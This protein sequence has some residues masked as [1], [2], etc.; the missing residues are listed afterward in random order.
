M[1]RNGIRQGDIEY[2]LFP[3]Y[4]GYTMFL[5]KIALTNFR[6]YADFKHTFK[7]NVL[8]LV[9]PNA[10]GKT[11]FL[12]SISVLS[13]SKSFRT[14][15]DSELIQFD[16][17]FTRL[18]GE[19][20][21]T[22]K[23]TPL[24]ITVDRL[25]ST[26]KKTIK[27]NS[28]P[29]RALDLV[30]KMTTVLFT[31]DDLNLVFASPSLRRRYLDTTICQLDPAYCRDLTEYR[32]VVSNKNQLLWAIKEGRA[33]VAELDFWNDKLAKIG[34]RLMASRRQLIKFYNTYLTDI[35]GKIN[36]SDEPLVIK[37][38]P[39]VTK[40]FQ[41]ELVAKQDQEIKQTSS[42]VGPHRD[43]FDLQL[44]KRKLAT[45][46]SRGE[47]RSTI[48][49]LKFAE[50]DFFETKLGARPILLLDDIFSELDKQRRSSLLNILDKQQTIITTT[51]LEFIDGGAVKTGEVLKVGSH[52]N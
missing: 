30:G 45:F 7:K 29:A 41:E 49:A 2:V 50:L 5:S 52:T 51:D 23:K 42:L 15:R 48:I 17:D 12:E 4:V 39:N 19:V 32:Q 6:N 26:V 44:N 37:Y 24:V 8:F 10:A 3:C 40:D 18:E 38:R 43:D 11:N 35:Y 13:L 25:G 33:I 20:K 34:T 14:R 16:Q 21:L 31:P 22:T 47:V 1:T 28:N 36:Q 9:G 46:G 27:I